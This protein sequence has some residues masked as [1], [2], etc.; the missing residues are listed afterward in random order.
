MSDHSTGH[1]QLMNAVYRN[2][3]FIYDI[4]RKYY[5]LGRDQLIEGLDVPPGGTVL[6]VACGTG[7]NLIK[8]GQR[9]PNAQL[10]GFDIST[11]MLTTARANLKR[12][13]LSDRT[14][15][16]QADAT[17]FTAQGLFGLPNF[18]RV[19]ISYSLSMIPDWQTA[20]ARSLGQTA[21]G[22]QLALVDFS[23]QKQLPRWFSKGLLSWLA[24]F[25]VAPRAE[26]T[27][28]IQKL[29]AKNGGTADV[30]H[31]YRDYAVL[32]RIRPPLPNAGQT[33]P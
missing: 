29:V 7:R 20:L 22:G 33:A 26:L 11:E 21:P 8:V 5:L 13:G 14:T 16:V 3:R 15:L 28:Q 24:L 9:Y 2:Q 4:T 30:D 6:E 27:A 19:F 32:G 12:A 10:F 18:D 25:H 23:Q 1:D 17:D 31:L